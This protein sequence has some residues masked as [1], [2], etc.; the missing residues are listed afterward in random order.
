MKKC[1]FIVSF[2][3]I[4]FPIKAQDTTYDI[5]DKALRENKNLLKAKMTAQDYNLAGMY[6]YERKRWPEAEAMFSEASKMD[7]YHVLAHYNLACVISI[8]LS[9]VTPSQYGLEWYNAIIG[10][11]FNKWVA[12]G[13]L[14][15]SIKLDNNRGSK[16]RQD[17]DFTN[18]K[19]L[20]PELFDAVTLPENQRRKYSYNLVF[21]DLNNFEGD[22]ALIFA[23][24]GNE[25][26]SDKW[27]WFDARDKGFRESNLWYLI[28]DEKEME[29]HGYWK[30]ND[31]MIGRTF[32]IVYIHD[33][34][35]SSYVGGK[36]VYLK[37]KLVSIKYMK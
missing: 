22:L 6:F 11:S 36:G 26:N 35:V 1:F 30:V 25:N 28:E 10:E 8:R 27:Y 9:L 5:L 37:N 21:V 12:A 2:I 20:D 14:K 15:Y 33:S 4:C 19:T 31:K 34:E 18:L 32:E 3:C 24:A 23:E 13:F 7:R 16:A 29:I 17:P